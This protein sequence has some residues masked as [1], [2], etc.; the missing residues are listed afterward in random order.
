MPDWTNSVV[1][2][3]RR[4]GD[5]YMAARENTVYAEK[6][7]GEA[8]NAAFD[9]SVEKFPDA[10]QTDYDVDDLDDWVTVEMVEGEGKATWY[11]R[12]ISNTE[13]HAAGDTPSEAGTSAHY[14]GK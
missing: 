10:I 9:G 7:N 8:V 4:Q 11:A 2:K 6:F 12:P 13:T 14:D 5:E 3:I 1:I